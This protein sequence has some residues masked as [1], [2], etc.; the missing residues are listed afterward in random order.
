MIDIAG[1]DLHKYYG[2]NHVI[3]GITFEI[4]SGEKVGLLGQ[5]GSGKT[6]LF[7]MLTGEVFFE[8]GSLC[9]AS[10]KNIEM[11]SQ[12]PVFGDAAAVED[13]LR[14]SFARITDVYK[15]MNKLAGNAQPKALARYGRLMEEYERLGGYETEVKLDKICTGMHIDDTMRKSRFDT[16]SG[17]EKTRVNL[18][19]ILLKDCDIL[20]LDEPT[21]HLDLASVQWL[22]GFLRRF[23]VRCLSS[24]TTGLFW[25]R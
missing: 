3:R 23:A 21:N 18:A 11:L 5:N 1:T 20:L 2:T 14:S 7:Q 25:I 8:N 15:E 24:P 9:K 17:G 10:G 13:V 22:E 19:R 12:I 16:L 4:Y 6:T